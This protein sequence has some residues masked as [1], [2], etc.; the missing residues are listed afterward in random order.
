MECPWALCAA[1]QHMPMPN[2]GSGQLAE[3]CHRWLIPAVLL[4]LQQCVYTCN[5]QNNTCAVAR[6]VSDGQW[7]KAANEGLCQAHLRFWVL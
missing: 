5:A 1:G 2:A 4:A 7:L 6:A 3:W